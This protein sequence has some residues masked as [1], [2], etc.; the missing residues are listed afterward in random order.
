M[1]IEKR[2]EV[3]EAYELVRRSHCYHNLTKE[4]FHSVLRYLGSKDGFEGVYS[5]IWYDEAEGRFGKKKGGRMIY[6][7]NLGTIP[8][9]ANY[10][11][12][13]ER[14][15]MVGDLSEK[16]VER[17]APR[18]VF[19][20]GGRSYEYIR[21]KGMK[22]FAR[23]ASGRKPTV[24]SWS[25]EMLPRSFDLSVEIAK[26]RREIAERLDEPEES[27]MEWLSTDFD[28]D[29]GSARSIDL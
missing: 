5:K 4:S 14:G 26:F 15:A 21:T 17:L 8:E 22:A 7:L 13:N 12:L 28:I 3:D 25:G 20:L 2:W 16:F 23:S 10:K 11:V 19:V 9:E 24:P 27:L 18:D 29:S 1:S 6:F